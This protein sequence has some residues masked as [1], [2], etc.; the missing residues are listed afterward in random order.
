MKT[1]YV[2]GLAT[3]VVG[4][5]LIKNPC[6]DYFMRVITNIINISLKINSSITINTEIVEM[7]C[8]NFAK[9]NYYH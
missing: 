8:H 5:D 4:L 1:V 3:Y 6:D 7:R 2:F 9:I